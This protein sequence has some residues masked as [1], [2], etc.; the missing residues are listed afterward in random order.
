MSKAVITVQ[1]D[2]H[3]ATKALSRILRLL[4]FCRDAYGV[5]ELTYTVEEDK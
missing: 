3:G 2:Y 5:K 1:L 4:D